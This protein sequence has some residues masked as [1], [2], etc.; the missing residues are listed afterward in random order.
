M[1]CNIVNHDIDLC[2]LYIAYREVDNS[3]EYY[4]SLKH[5][6]D[7]LPFSLELLESINKLL[8]LTSIIKLSQLLNTLIF[9]PITL[10]D[11][12]FIDSVNE[13]KRVNKLGFYYLNIGDVLD[14]KT[15]KE[16]YKKAALIHHPDKGGDLVIMIIVNEAYTQFK[17]ILRLN[18]LEKDSR[19]IEHDSMHFIINILIMRIRIAVFHYDFPQAFSFYSEYKTLTSECAISENQLLSLIEC[20]RKIHKGFCL[21]E[22][23][24]KQEQLLEE[25]IEYCNQFAM[26][27]KIER[28]KRKSSFDDLLSSIFKTENR[29]PLDTKKI[30]HKCRLNMEV[31]PRVI[32]RQEMQANNAFSLGIITFSRYQKVI[33]QSLETKSQFHLNKT[34]FQ[35]LTKS[36]GF[37]V[38]LNFEQSIYSKIPSFKQQRIVP[39]PDYYVC[40]IRELSDKQLVEYFESFRTMDVNKIVK[41]YFVRLLSYIHSSVYF[42]SCESVM[43]MHKELETINHTL[44]VGNDSS[45]LFYGSK[46][47]AFLTNLHKAT[48]DSVPIALDYIKTIINR[49]ATSRRNIRRNA[50]KESKVLQNV[51][52]EENTRPKAKAKGEV[53]EL[54]ISDTEI[55]I[56]TL[57]PSFVQFLCMDIERM[58]NIVLSGEELYLL[59]S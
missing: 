42:Y 47:L 29:M 43:I 1:D 2:N 38:P 3:L 55:P 35:E 22:S 13:A 4:S 52:E 49:E 27:H 32:I 54:V 25:I 16:K 17:E 10:I 31:K 11:T 39:E 50:K 41:Y 36:I 44:L 20:L 21:Y 23:R 59:D 51:L 15:L 26:I 46:V 8:E 56:I 53:R 37:T 9:N 6:A 24:K 40:D 28:S 14:E 57:H 34:H 18:K 48:P 12:C 7:K 45:R 5:V 58:R 19:F 33:A 30:I